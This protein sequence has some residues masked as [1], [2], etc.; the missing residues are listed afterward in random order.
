MLTILRSKLCQKDTQYYIFSS[1]RGFEPNHSENIFFLLLKHHIS[2][3][4]S[5]HMFL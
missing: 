2:L 5:K 3:T 4:L 1:Y